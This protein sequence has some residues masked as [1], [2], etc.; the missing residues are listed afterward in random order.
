[1]KYFIKTYGCQMNF[2]DSRHVDE[3]LS[4]N[5]ITKSE[6]LEDADFVIV[7]TCSVRKHAEDRALG[8]IK[9]ISNRVEN[10]IVIGCLAVHR[11]EELRKAGADIVK[12]QFELE[13]II[14][15]ISKELK[16]TEKFPSKITA[17]VPIVRGCD[18]F[19]SYCIVPYLRGPVISISPDDILNEIND[20]TGRG[21]RIIQLLGQNVCRYDYNGY[22]FV[23]LLRDVSKVE[24]LK[25]ISFLTTHPAD[26]DDS[27]IDIMAKTDNIMKYIHLPIQSGSD[28]LLKSMFRGYTTVLYKKIIIKIRERI[29]DVRIT[30]D[31]MV[32]LPGEEEED[33]L[34]TLS[35]VKDICFD[36]AYMFAFSPRE[37]SLDNLK[38]DILFEKERKRRLKILIEV[39]RNIT[40]VKKREKIGR[41]MEVI[42]IKRAKSEELFFSIGEDGSPVLI[43]KQADPGDV[44]S[45]RISSLKGGSLFGEVISG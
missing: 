14:S 45:V 13:D 15:K 40:M 3:L 6:S 27:I 18:R 12:Y 42:V 22:S 17:E 35:L 43:E 39:Q 30:T 1:L 28:K 33:F 25:K 37:G 29:P 16:A 41:T 34:S 7:N 23:D 26:L 24:G 19:C 4:R 10:L 32:G 20:L 8:W 5:D 36:E 9:S 11:E 31:I 2:A 21:T 44:F 38:K